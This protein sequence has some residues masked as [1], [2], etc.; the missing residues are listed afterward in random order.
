MGCKENFGKSSIGV[1]DLSYPEPVILQTHWFWGLP[2]SH[3][4]RMRKEPKPGLKRIIFH[5]SKKED[6]H[7]H[8]Q[9]C[10]KAEPKRRPGKTPPAQQKHRVLGSWDGRESQDWQPPSPLIRGLPPRQAAQE[11]FHTHY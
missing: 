11:S 8:R 6:C 1:A 3:P 10:S 5:H 7:C 9:S 4:Y 2:L